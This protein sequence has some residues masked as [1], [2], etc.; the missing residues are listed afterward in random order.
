[1]TSRRRTL[2]VLALVLAAVVVAAFQ[3]AAQTPTTRII[4]LA[5]RVA[6]DL[7]RAYDPHQEQVWRVTSWDSTSRG[8]YTLITVLGVAYVATG[9]P[10]K[11][12]S[13][14]VAKLGSDPSIHFHA[15]GN[16]QASPADRE[17]SATRHAAFDG[18]LCGDRFAVWYFADEI[19]AA[20]N[21]S[22][23]LAQQ[24]ASR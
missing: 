1:M 13:H 14:D 5:P 17:A 6:D 4:Q 10:N 21:Y 15:I 9:E 8:D 7:A 20:Q 16:C 11:I 23:L 2:L 19:I 24:Q 22:F 3:L 12:A 18:I